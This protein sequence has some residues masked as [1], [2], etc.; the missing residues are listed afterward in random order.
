M[1]RGKCGMASVPE[2]FLDVFMD[3]NNKCNL[4][5]RM[6]GFSD[7]RVKTIHHYD[8]PFWL[9]EKIA[10]ETFP[11]TKYLALSCL[12]EPLMTRDLLDRI[13]LAKK[14]QVPFTEMITNGTMLKEKIISELL[15]SSLTRLGVS[16]D[17]ANAATY[18][19][20]RIGASFNSVICNIRRFVE[21]RAAK[22]SAFPKLRLLH[23]I[24]ERNIDEFSEFLDLAASLK[25][26]AIDVRT[27]TAIGKAE[28]QS[29]DGESFWEKIRKCRNMLT[30]WA[31]KTAIE[32]TSALRYQPEEIQLFDHSGEKLTCRRPWN[33]LAIH[34]SGNVHPCM[35]WSRGPVGNMAY[36]SFD[37]IWNRQ[38]L[39]E[40]REEFTAEKPGVDCQHCV[41][42][43]DQSV[44][45]DPDFFFKMLN[46]MPP[47]NRSGKT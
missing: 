26:D 47:E 33:T 16:L 25:V 34:A 43:K 5:C 27:I 30:D 31:E 9:Y 2:R 32:D 24:S 15:S 39:K 3:Q 1:K 38:T 42:K 21:I 23:V 7:P 44:D 20:I 40:I 22:G 4:M 37:Q 29:S 28:L 45:E 36:E 6:C 10:E 41:I 13:H 8:M 18:E 12:T 46:S 14:Y 11:F 35:S 17:G 19:S